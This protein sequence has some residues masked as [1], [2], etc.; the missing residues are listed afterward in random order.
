MWDRPILP[1]DGMYELVEELKRA[2]Y[3]IYLLSNA[4][5]RQREYWPREPCQQF[6]DGVLIS[7]DIGSVKPERKLY[8]TLTERFQLKPEECF[9]VDD[10]PLNVTGAL[11]CG[12]SGTVFHGDAAELRAEMRSAGI[13]VNEGCETA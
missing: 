13:R 2:G 9:F 10:S 1:I 3:G 7:S 4:S 11:R 5:V 6:F 12:W 8:E